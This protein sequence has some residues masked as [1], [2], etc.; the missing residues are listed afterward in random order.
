MA[1]TQTEGNGILNLV[2]ETE[3]FSANT[4]VEHIQYIFSF[5]DIDVTALAVS[6]PADNCRVNR[7]IL[8][9]LQTPYIFCKNHLL[10]LEVNRIVNST[11]ELSNVI[12]SV[13]ATMTQCKQRLKNA[14]LLRNM[15]EWH[16][17]LYYQTRWSGKFYLLQRF[18][19]TWEHLVKMDGSAQ[20]DVDVNTSTAFKNKVKGLLVAIIG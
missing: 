12:D 16:P 19:Q 2:E 5:Y 1:N 7:K 3:E 4:H 13:S 9:L 15:V 17:I 11:V 8:D 20:A 10:N 14:P 18:L 6:Q